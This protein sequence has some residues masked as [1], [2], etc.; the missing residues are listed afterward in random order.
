MNNP[1]QS[2]KAS[3]AFLSGVF[4]L[5]LALFCW[6]KKQEPIAWKDWTMLA[7]STFRMS[8]MVAYD[9]VMQT[10]RAPFAETVPHDSGAGDTT[11]A[12]P[13]TGFKRAVGELI[14][15][16]I[17]NGTWISA[18]LVYGLCLA[19]N[20][21]RTLMTVMS[22]VGAAEILQSAFEAVQ[23][24]GELLRHKTGEQMR[25]N[26]AATQQGDEPAGGEQA[27]LWLA[28]T[29]AEMQRVARPKIE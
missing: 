13:G 7:L 10:Y 21:T 23:W 11:Q 14:T 19:P 9:T 5:G 16:P 28:P 18:G 3:Y 1:T 26:R 29:Q 12:K 24:G 27:Q 15:C 2:T 22:A 8:R 20:Y 4:N 25:I 6:R 17:C